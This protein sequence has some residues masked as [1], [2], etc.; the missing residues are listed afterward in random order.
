MKE[1]I[2]KP[3][4][5]IPLVEPYDDI[6]KIISKNIDENTIEV[7]DGDIFV[8]A[9]KV[10]SKSENR[11]INI[12]SVQPTKKAISLSKKLNKDARIIQ[13]ILN[14]SCEIISYKNN[15]LVTRHNLGFVNVNAGIDFSNIFN[16]KDRVLLLPLE[17]NESAKKINQFL[18][19]KYKKKISIIITDSQTRPFRKG[20]ASF[21]IGT[22]NF[23]NLKDYKGSK[24]I[25]NNKM[26]L[27]ESALSDL[28][29]SASA[30][31]MGEGNE[32]IPV[33]IVKGFPA[34]KRLINKID[35]IYTSKI[36]DIYKV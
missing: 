6:G 34:Q 25:Y 22:H 30:L 1:I 24:D 5:E 14:E 19:N 36:E 32:M 20:V 35:E 23:S 9:Q 2:I 31:L 15:V 17:P 16:N 11:F 3:L 33:V 12:D 7:E 4:L 29:A 21:A 10:V 18:T 26:H 13:I 28:I 27:T 8:I